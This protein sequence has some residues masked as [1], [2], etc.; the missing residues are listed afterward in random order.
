LVYLNPCGCGK[1]SSA[2]PTRCLGL[3]LPRIHFTPLL[4]STPDSMPSG[5]PITHTMALCWRDSRPAIYHHRVRRYRVSSKRSETVKKRPQVME[6]DG[7]SAFGLRDSVVHL[8]LLTGPN[9][10]DAPIRSHH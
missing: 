10:T 7:K 3:S 9:T 8:R 4:S 5:N 6:T 1:R 2:N